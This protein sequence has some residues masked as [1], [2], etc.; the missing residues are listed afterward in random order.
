VL[1]PLLMGGL[2]L[3]CGAVAYRW[4]RVRELVASARRSLA[5]AALFRKPTSGYEHAMRNMDAERKMAEHL[6]AR[7]A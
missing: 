5:A 2:A 6:G 7:S 4:A 1:L 3:L